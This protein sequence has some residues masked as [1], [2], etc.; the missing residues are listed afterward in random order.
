MQ[1][2]LLFEVKGMSQLSV[3]RWRTFNHPAPTVGNYGC[4]QIIDTRTR[5]I[6]L[7]EI[8][9]HHLHRARLESKTVDEQT[10]SR[11]LWPTASA[12]IR[13]ALPQMLAGYL[14]QLRDTE[15]PN[16]GN[17]RQMF[18]FTVYADGSHSWPAITLMTQDSFAATPA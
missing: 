2:A 14:Y 6:H 11:A 4:C 15:L 9:S 12:K 13:A 16:P 8:C 17:D 5:V 3:N 10:I 18:S 7:V 1:T